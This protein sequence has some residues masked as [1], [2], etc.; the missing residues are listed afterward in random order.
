MQLVS[1]IIQD[2]CDYINNEELCSEADFPQEMTT[3]KDT[4]DKIEA[5]SN[6]NV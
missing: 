3:F 4:L 1:E 6:N 5:Y 2:M